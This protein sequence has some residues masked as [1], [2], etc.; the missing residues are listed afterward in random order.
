FKEEGNHSYRWKQVQISHS[1]NS[2]QTPLFLANVLKPVPKNDPKLMERLLEQMD[3]PRFSARN[4]AEK[5]LR[6]LQARE[7]L[8]NALTQRKLSAQAKSQIESVLADWQNKPL[9]KQET[10]VWRSIEVLECIG[11]QNAILVLKHIA[12][13]NPE[14]I[15][16]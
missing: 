14:S 3:N 11:N 10:R 15:I 16:T 2:K 4:Q 13:G 5:A 9:S 1:T 8:Q 12:L 7:F 6:E